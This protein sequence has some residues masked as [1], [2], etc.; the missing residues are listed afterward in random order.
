MMILYVCRAKDCG[1]FRDMTEVAFYGGYA[2]VNT[3][4]LQYNTTVTHCPNGHGEMYQV[5]KGD[6]LAVL[7]VAVESEKEGKDE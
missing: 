3:R 7:P 5:Q 4:T 2:G 6:R 1:Y